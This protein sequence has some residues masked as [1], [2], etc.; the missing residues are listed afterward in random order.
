MPVYPAFYPII[1]SFLNK[2]LLSLIMHSQAKPILFIKHFK[3]SNCWTK[4]LNTGIEISWNK[5]SEGIVVF[6]PPD[7]HWRSVMSCCMLRRGRGGGYR[8]QREATIVTW[9]ASASFGWT[10]GDNCH[11][12]RR[13]EETRTGWKG[14]HPEKSNRRAE[15]WDLKPR[16]NTL[17]WITHP[18]TLQRLCSHLHSLW[19]SSWE[20][21]SF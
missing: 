4:V 9:A 15:E 18:D 2:N 7:R 3:N 11:I 12:G 8:L 19:T 14:P 21:A 13:K 20:I 6:S 5:Y 10:A 16:S 1:L 17:D